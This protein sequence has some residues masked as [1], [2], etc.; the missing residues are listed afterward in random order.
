MPI[1]KYAKLR[2]V[3]APVRSLPDDAGFDFYIPEFNYEL[4]RDF[5]EKNGK[6]IST[7][8]KACTVTPCGY[9]IHLQPGERCMV[10]SGIAVDVPK[11]YGLFA[12]EKSGVGTAKG[13]L[14]TSRLVDPGYQ[15]E[16]YI[17]LGKPC[18][19]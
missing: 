18:K 15:G 1:L 17:S 5:K 2:I 8:Y 9:G 3:K 16:I 11:G 13:L 4:Q 14:F 7:L 12:F 19:Y 6:D 10:P